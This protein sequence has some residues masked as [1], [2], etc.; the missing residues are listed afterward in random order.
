MSLPAQVEG[1]NHAFFGSVVDGT[2]TRY[3]FF[4]LGVLLVFFSA[5]GEGSLVIGTAFLLH[6][7]ERD[8]YTNR[9]YVD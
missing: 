2:T 9:H 4:F 1:G 5:H 7:I 3:V 8:D 6:C